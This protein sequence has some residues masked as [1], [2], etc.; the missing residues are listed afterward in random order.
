MPPDRKQ[1]KPYVKPQV[2]RVR[3]EDKRVVSMGA[4]KT[5]PNDKACTDDVGNPAYNYG[6]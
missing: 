5:G 2:T 4:C 6:S 3:L 1:R